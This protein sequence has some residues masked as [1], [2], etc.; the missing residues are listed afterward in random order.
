MPAGDQ[1][2]MQNLFSQSAILAALLVIV[3]FMMSYSAIM[4]D[5]GDRMTGPAVDD[6]GRESGTKLDRT[7]LSITHFSFWIACLVLALILVLK[8]IWLF[9]GH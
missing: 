8:M 2:D 5:L 6:A 4:K 7:L 3:I 1:K 9:S